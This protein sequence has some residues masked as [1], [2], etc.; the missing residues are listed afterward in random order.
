LTTWSTL[1]KYPSIV[2]SSSLLTATL[3]TA[4]PSGV[5][6]VGVRGTTSRTDGFFEVVFSNLTIGAHNAGIAIS[7]SSQSLNIYPHNPNACAWF[8]DGYIAGPGVAL[9]GGAPSFAAGDVLGVEKSGSTIRFLKNGTVVYTFTTIP[10]GSLFPHL[11]LTTVGDSATAN[12]GATAF[13]HFPT[14]AVPWDTAPISIPV[15]AGKINGVEI[16]GTG[17]SSNPLVW[18]S[19]L[20]QADSV[21]FARRNLSRSGG[22]TI[23]LNR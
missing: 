9:V 14:G 16:V 1:D 18:P 8:A 20:L 10:T 5:T 22:L 13:A 4:L 23:E 17:S 6:D 21:M 19:S 12:F 11:S 2:L 7:N 3:T 15:A